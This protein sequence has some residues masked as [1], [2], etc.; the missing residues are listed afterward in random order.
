MNFLTQ[1]R[2][3]LF[4]SMLN[5]LLPASSREVSITLLQLT[6][7]LTATTGT[8]PL[9]CF[10][11]FVKAFRAKVQDNK[12]QKASQSPG[13]VSNKEIIVSNVTSIDE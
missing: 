9:L 10:W 11:E 2:I 4:V 5:C 7:Q 8:V 12:G 3:C 1:V 13:P 6:G